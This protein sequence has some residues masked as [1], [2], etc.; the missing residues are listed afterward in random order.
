MKVVDMHCD[1]IGALYEAEQRGEPVSLLENDLHLDLKKMEKG[2]YFLQNFAL[3]VDLGHTDE[4]F[5]TCVSMADL[6]YREMEK[7]RDRIAPVTTWKEMEENWRQGKMSALLT[8]EEGEVCEGNPAFLRTL[9]RLGARMMTLT[10][11]YENSLAWPGKGGGVPETERGLKQRGF[12]ILEEMES[13]G[14]IVDVSHLSDAGIL[15]VLKAAKKPFVASHS[16]ARSLASHSRNLTDEMI[17]G[18]AEK[19]GVIGINYCCSFLEDIPEGQKPVS[20]IARI[21]DH[22]KHIRQVGGIGCLGLGSDYDGITGELELPT[23]AAL[24]RLAEAMEEAGFTASEVED[25][26]YRNVLGLYRELL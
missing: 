17:R 7:N 12:E 2:D 19:G 9:Y 3:F 5:K 8:L 1:T 14:M 6:F 4:P 24:P 23:A 13:L 21:I 10:W 16:D 22:M 18:I 20:R 11:N 26:F 15:D 25:V